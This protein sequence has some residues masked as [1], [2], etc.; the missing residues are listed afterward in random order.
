MRRDE[1]TI[2]GLSTDGIAYCEAK[3]LSKVFAAYAEDTGGRECIM[4]IGFNSNSGIVYIA[5][6]NSVQICSS[7]G[8]DVDYLVTDTETG[9]ESWYNTYDEAIDSLTKQNE[10]V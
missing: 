6:E 10:E 5:L 4:Y 1:L 3:G 9:E 8:Q 2:Y 7:F